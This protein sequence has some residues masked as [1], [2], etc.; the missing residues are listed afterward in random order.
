ML[1]ARRV[2]ACRKTGSLR[3][4]W[5]RTGWVAPVAAKKKFPLVRALDLALA[6]KKL[7]NGKECAF[8]SNYRIAVP[9]DGSV[10]SARA[11]GRGYG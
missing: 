8:F 11:A 10:S 2:G 1:D 3:A 6:T 9:G 7:G 4:F 5:L